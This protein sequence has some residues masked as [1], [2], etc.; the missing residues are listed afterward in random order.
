MDHSQ[1][2][3]P[4][5]LLDTYEA[6]AFLGLKHPGT[7]VNWRCKRRGPAYISIGR[8]IRYQLVDLQRWI[9]ANRVETNAVIL[10]ST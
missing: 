3:L 8:S 9:E 2:G 4:S 10:T 1:P 5:A 6:A 7:L